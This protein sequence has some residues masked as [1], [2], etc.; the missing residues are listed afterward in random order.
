[1]FT[2]TG[3]A[4]GETRFHSSATNLD[5]LTIKNNGQVVGNFVQSSSKELKENITDFSTQEAIETL[6]ALNPVK[7]NYRKDNEKKLIFGFI[8]EDMPDLLAT[9]GRKGVC[10]VEIVAV[11]TKVIKDQ[12]EKLSLLRERVNALEVKD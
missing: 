12:Q 3:K 9:H 6:T 10:A 1:M 5:L 4:Q 2:N 7:F 11:L 8:A